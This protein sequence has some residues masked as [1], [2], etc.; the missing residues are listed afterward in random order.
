[1][2]EKKPETT[3]P[4]EPSE[5]ELG[6]SYE[7]VKDTKPATVTTLPVPETKK[8]PDIIQNVFF[9]LNNI[10]NIDCR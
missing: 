6:I 3:N 4:P 8:E 10:K 2:T 1:M 9:V 7:E 5:E